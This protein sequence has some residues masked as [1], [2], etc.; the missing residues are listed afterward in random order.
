MASFY[1]INVNLISAATATRC[2]AAELIAKH[3]MIRCRCGV[4]AT[5]MHALSTELIPAHFVPFT[6]FFIC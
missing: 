6:P 5:T 1:L 4:S 2:T 3:N